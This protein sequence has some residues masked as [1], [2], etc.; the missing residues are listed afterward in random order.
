MF[1]HAE[2]IA[3]SFFATPLWIFKV[4]QVLQGRGLLVSYFI[5]YIVCIVWWWHL[6]NLMTVT[7]LLKWCDFLEVSQLSFILGIFA[8][9]WFLLISCILREK[10][11]LLPRSSGGKSDTDFRSLYSCISIFILDI[12]LWMEST[13]SKQVEKVQ[14][15]WIW[16]CWWLIN[17]ALCTEIHVLSNFY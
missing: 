6:W 4:W 2:P 14:T 17:I 11:S 15:V 13:F 9:W 7:T 10:L 5:I 3:S 8:K 16:L 1:W 12:S